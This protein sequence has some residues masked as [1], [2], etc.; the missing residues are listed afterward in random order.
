M[1]YSDYGG[2]GFSRGDYD[3]DYGY[4]MGD[5]FGGG[6]GYGRGGGGREGGFREGGFREG[7]FREGRGGGG[8][9]GRGG[10]GRGFGSPGWGR[11]MGRGGGVRNPD[12]YE[13]E[14]DYGY[15]GRVGRDADDDKTKVANLNIC[16]DYVRGACHRGNRCPKPHVD[17]VES[18]DERE[19][20]SKVKF[21]HDFQNR[22][23]CVRAGCK[24]LHVTRTE[25]DEFLLTGSIPPAV[26]SRMQESVVDDPNYTGFDSGSGG[27]GGGPRGRGGG[28]GGRG[29]GVRGR[30]GLGMKRSFDGDQ[31]G[32]SKFARGAG[33]GRGGRGGRGG[34][35][36]RGRGGEKH[37]SSQPIT[38]GDICVDYL[39]GTCSKGSDCQLMH[40]ETI[41]GD[42]QRT[43]L[44]SCVFCHDFQNGT[45]GR[46]FCKFVHASRQ[47][48]SF[49]LE[50]GYF[51]PSLNARNKDKLFFSD[52]CLDYLR[53]QCIRG[54]RCY[55]RHVDRVESLNERLCLSR[56]IFCHD[57]QEGGCV[58]YPC[59]MVHTSKQ[60]EDYFVETGYFP[61]GLNANPEGAG[62][63]NTDNL[64]NLS[65]IAENVCRE[66][67]KNQC[68]RG[69][70]CKFYHPNRQELEVLL[71]QPGAAFRGGMGR[72]RGRG[73]MTGRGGRGG[74]MGGGGGGGGGMG[75]GGMGG[76]G[77]QNGG[78]SGGLGEMQASGGS[79]NPPENT[80]LKSRVNQLE[81]L[82]ADACYC[83]TLAVGD[84]NP[85][86]STLMKTI[87]D[88][89]PDSALPNQPGSSGDGNK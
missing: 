48:E 87:S 86:I 58:R 47:E 56:S 51:P 44:I 24:F 7:G 50:N 60:D 39:K 26:F 12:Y 45:C 61:K 31:G 28:R 74:G 36:G 57:F 20:L 19:I 59:K 77:G 89:A 33:G 68:T 67:V 71:S 15:Q 22:G 65:H 80:A 49:F 35:R 14:S 83:M 52:I 46:D 27:R 75:A 3:Y 63:V 70:G 13:R 17:Y 84:Q 10:G 73:G 38:F 21:C 4:R 32:F 37:S 62:K 11:G 53:S 85:A 72:G 34:G 81:R 23:E 55:Y 76:G 30:G 43:G 1:A 25:E 42:D 18:I 41:D 69:S 78:P 40:Y 54:T 8:R 88:M 82:L 29:G 2:G 6:N 64:P 79:E 9:E 66:F 16:V 5:G